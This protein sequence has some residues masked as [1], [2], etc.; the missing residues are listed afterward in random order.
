MNQVG[1]GYSSPMGTPTSQ[2]EALVR[3]F[4]KWVGGK[5][6]FLS[7]YAHLLPVAPEGRVIEPFAG[8]AA[9]SLHY[10]SQQAG[11]EVWL[12]DSNEALVQCYVDIRDGTEQ[13]ICDY[14]KLMEGYS[15]AESKEDFY[16][17]VRDRFN[18]GARRGSEFLFLNRTGFNG[19]YRVNKR[20]EFNVS[21]GRCHRS[22]TYQPDAAHL[23]AVGTALKSATVTADDW[24][25]VCI[26]AEPGDLVFL[27]PP[28]YSDILAGSNAAKYS[29]DRFDYS[30]HEDLA[31]W[32]V[33]LEENDI[34]YIL[35]NSA[36]SGMITLYRGLG[37][38]PQLIQSPRRINSKV[39][40]RASISE[41]L[42]TNCQGLNYG[43]SSYQPTLPSLM[44]PP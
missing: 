7:R 23:R 25:D 28:Y 27:D 42:V 43:L 40:R 38:Y 34:N 39:S 17:Q 20:G 30:D 10:L 33:Q 16:Y 22:T 1:F 11:T 2:G 29:A 4:L 5:Q 44:S 15:S 32:V 9:F 37:L 14:L 35:T 36:E 13:F 19:L 6:H 8:G 18:Q 24:R 41:V 26:Q 3:P 21:H 31:K 12:N